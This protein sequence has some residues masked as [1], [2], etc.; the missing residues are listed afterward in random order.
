MTFLIEMKSGCHAPC[1]KLSVNQ[2]WCEMHC[3]GVNSCLPVLCIRCPSQITCLQLNYCGI[4]M[5]NGVKPWMGTEECA[6]NL[7]VMHPEL[8]VAC[9]STL[10][11]CSLKFMYVHVC[12]LSKYVRITWHQPEELGSEP[13]S[14]LKGVKGWSGGTSRGH[15]HV[16]DVVVVQSSPFWDQGLT[17]SCSSSVLSMQSK[18]FSNCFHGIANVYVDY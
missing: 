15:F 4:I 7:V 5:S 8:A 16:T 3:H 1:A 14:Y 12:R 17:D 18:T 11:T 2:W 9:S 13:V 6:W 10:T